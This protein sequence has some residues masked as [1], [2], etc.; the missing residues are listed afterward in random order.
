MGECRDGRVK[1]KT[2]ADFREFTLV[3]HQVSSW[4]RDEIKRKRTDDESVRRDLVEQ[5]KQI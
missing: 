1:R 3:S 2:D 5:L 4:L